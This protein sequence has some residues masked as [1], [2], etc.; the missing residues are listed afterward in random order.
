MNLDNLRS[1]ARSCPWPPR[2][3]SLADEIAWQAG[4]CPKKEIPILSG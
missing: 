1:P 2:I 3:A 4:L